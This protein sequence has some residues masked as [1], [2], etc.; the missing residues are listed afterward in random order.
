[1]GV[2]SQPKTVTRQRRD[3]DLNP[4]PL[5]PESSTLTTQIPSHPLTNSTLPYFT[6]YF[7]LLSAFQSARVTN[8]AVC[9]QFVNNCINGRTRTLSRLVC[10]ATCRFNKSDVVKIDH[11]SLQRRCYYCDIIAHM[12]AIDVDQNATADGPRDALYQLYVVNCC[13]T[14][15]T[16]CTQTVV[17]LLSKMRWIPTGM[18]L[19]GPKL[20][21]EGP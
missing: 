10:I 15:A 12:H 8:V 9:V 1:M 20:E 6:L 13:T 16:C 2:S 4:G 19:E 17:K 7:Q 11:S 3:C 21:P 5:A 14:V 18:R